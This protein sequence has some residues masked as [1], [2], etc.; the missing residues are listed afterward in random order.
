MLLARILV[1][2]YFEEKE[3][4][5]KFYVRERI[6]WEQYIAELTAEGDEAIQ[7]LYRKLCSCLLKRNLNIVC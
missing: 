5:T 7:Q 1:S 2:E 6:A 4:R 3:E